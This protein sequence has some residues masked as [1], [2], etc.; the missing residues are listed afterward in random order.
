MEMERRKKY[1]TENNRR[2]SRYKGEGEGDAIIIMIK[3]GK[4]SIGE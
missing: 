4:N 3:D 2:E 1:I